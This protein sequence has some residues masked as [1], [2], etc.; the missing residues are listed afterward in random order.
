MARKS[1]ARVIDQEAEDTGTSQTLVAAA[2]A[3]HELSDRIAEVEQEYGV[4]MPYNLQA[5]VHSIRRHAAESAARLIEIGRMLILIREHETPDTYREALD[6]IGIAPRFAQRSM[7]AAIKL[8]DRTSLHRLGS[9]K[10]LELLSEDDET[11]DALEDGGT[12]A[13][14][15]LDELDSMS[16]RELK[17]ALRAERRERDEEKAADE[18]IIRAKDERI[19]KLTRGK[20]KES[21][22]D[23]LRADVADLLQQ[24]DQ[25]AVEATT[26]LATM[27]RSLTRI[28]EIYAEAGLAV[29]DDVQN[30][31]DQNRE[32]AASALAKLEV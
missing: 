19:N 17:A 11:L 18:E 25:A 10:V 8:Q 1:T 28:D 3:H 2:Q 14:L 29:D 12:V 4:D 23:N 32:W 5:F 26:Q 16:V 20:R 21:P 30:R 24:A 31:I 13:G 6:Q 15:T 9:S 22:E 7:Q 27:E